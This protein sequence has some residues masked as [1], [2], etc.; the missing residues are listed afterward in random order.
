QRGAGMTMARFFSPRPAPSDAGAISALLARDELQALDET[1]ARLMKVLADVAPR[2]STT[3][4][5][6]LKRLTK[7]R[8]ALLAALARTG[9]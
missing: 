3:V 1:R 2:R 9:R 4:E 5:T 8:V 7:R 6:E